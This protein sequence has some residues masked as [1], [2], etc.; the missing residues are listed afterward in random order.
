MVGFYMDAFFAIVLFSIG[1]IG[2]TS[3]ADFLKIFFSLEMLLN[4]VILIL[5]SAAYHLG[6]TRGLAIAY[7]IIVIAT[8][9]AAAGILIFIL[10][11]R[12]TKEII[13]DK[14]NKAVDDDL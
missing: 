14:M 7:V 6:L 13:P 5:A 2:V 8:L 4:A 3:K 10:S 9:E 11:Y 1:M 12:K